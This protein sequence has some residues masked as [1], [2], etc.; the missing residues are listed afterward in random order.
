LPLACRQADDQD[1]SPEP[2]SVEFGQIRKSRL[3]LPGWARPR[4]ATARSAAAL[5]LVA[6]CVAVVG[7][8]SHQGQGT[9]GRASPPW[10][11]T[12]GSV[13]V[14]RIRP[15]LLGERTRWDLVAVGTGWE[16]GAGHWGSLVRIQLATG[17]ITR[18]KFLGLSSDGPTAVIASSRQVLVRSIDGAPGYLVR[19]GRAASLIPAFMSQGG[20]TFPGPG[21]GQVWVGS[22]SRSVLRLVTMTGR[23]LGPV[24][25]LPADEPSA[26]PDDHGYLLMQARGGVYDVRPSGMRRV[27]SGVLL[28]VGPAAWLLGKCS[29]ARHCVDLLINPLNNA[30]RVQRAMAGLTGYPE[31]SFPPGLVSPDSRFAA[32]LTYGRDQSAILHVVDL[33]D[34]TARK[35][36]V[37]LGAQ[38]WPYLAWSPDSRWLF[39]VTGSGRL[40]AINPLTATVSAL[41]VALPPVSYLTI[42]DGG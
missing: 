36:D 27:A 28:A 40:C 10:F 14:T 35:V 5:V 2:D 30:R 20:P 16:P 12:G 18:T 7:L 34:G 42:Q 9:A 41:G 31:P 4:G 25:R 22:D 21:P 39:A 26:V 15:G 38:G 23:R 8:R 19:D 3:H 29:A 17:L 1:V 37:A 32:L 13:A 11:A 6:T 24:I 33:R